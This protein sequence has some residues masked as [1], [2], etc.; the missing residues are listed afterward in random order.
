VLLSDA[1]RAE[2]ESY[3]KA[4]QDPAYRLGQRR[5]AH[6]IQHLN[7]IP[8]GT[9]LDVSTGRGEVLEIA[10]HLGHGPVMGTEAVAYLCDGERIRHALAHDLPFG[11]SAFD[12]VTMFDVMEHLLPED[13]EA[14]CKELMRVASQRVLLTIHN[15]PH[16]FKGRDLH[17]NR[18]QDYTAWLYELARHFEGH[19]V[20]DLGQGDS[21]STMFEVILR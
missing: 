4:Y 12:T 8:K 7:R 17:I 5:R 15:G 13:T 10:E 21:I 19:E 3:E 2:I 9:L 16:V 14:V 11:T 1:R 18:R 20:I 6:I